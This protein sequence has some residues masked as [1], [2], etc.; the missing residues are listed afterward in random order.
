MSWFGL[1]A[2]AVAGLFVI[3]VALCLFFVGSRGDDDRLEERPGSEEPETEN[4]PQPAR[5][6]RGSIND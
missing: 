5:P 6:K 1:I 4:S 2:G 3:F